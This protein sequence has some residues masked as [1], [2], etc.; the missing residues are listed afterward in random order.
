MGI[1]DDFFAE[2]TTTEITP[3]V[4][5]FNDFFE[6][7]PVAPTPQISI[8]TPQFGTPSL[9]TT[10]QTAV[11][12]IE[13]IEAPQTKSVMDDFFSDV[14]IPQ[15]TPQVS[16]MDDFFGDVFIDDYKPQR[17][18]SLRITPERSFIQKITDPIEKLYA[19]SKERSANIL[20]LSQVTGLSITQVEKHYRQV[21]EDV[22]IKEQPSGLEVVKKT[23]ELAATGLIVSGLVAAPVV[24]LVG[25]SAF[26][27][28]KGTAEYVAL[29]AAKAAYQKLTSKEVQYEVT[30]LRD[31]VPGDFLKDTADLAEFV[32]YGMVA[33]KAVA[34]IKAL[35]PKVLGQIN[36]LRYRIGKAM[37]KKFETAVVP[38]GE[39]VKT[40]PA[41]VPTTVEP[42]DIIPGTGIKK[43]VFPNERSDRPLMR[44]VER[45]EFINKGENDFLT[46]P[47]KRMGI[48]DFFYTPQ[49]RM[50]QKSGLGRPGKITRDATLDRRIEIQA[51]QKFMVDAVSELK[52]DLGRRGKTSQ[53]DL[54]I[55]LAKV[56]NYMEH[57]VPET[58]KTPA[59]RFAKAM[60]Y[61]TEQMRIRINQI[62]RESGDK[63]IGNVKD[64]ILHTV[65]DEILH[66]ILNTGEVS[67]EIA[68]VLRY[69]PDKKV[70]LKTALERKEVPESWLVKDPIKLMDAMYKIDLK[71]TYLQDSLNRAKP[72][73]QFLEDPKKLPE[74]AVGF[75]NSV[76]KYWNYYKDHTLMNK[77]STLDGILNNSVDAVVGMVL[78]RM[79]KIR[80]RLNISH[81]PY[82]QTVNFILG[83]TYAG[84][85]G[86]RA[87]PILRNL[88]QGTFDW[89]MYGTKAYSKGV[90][91]R[92]TK[93]GRDILSQSKIWKTRTPFEF[94]L[95]GTSTYKKLVRAGSVPYR[96][97]DQQN[98][99]NAL[100]TRYYYAKDT[101]K[102]DHKKA[103]TFADNDLPN[104]QWSYLRED[105]PAAFMTTSGRAVHSLG[106]WW[107]NYYTRLLPEI[108]S[109]TILGKDVSGRKVTGVERLAGLRYFALIGALY[110][111]RELTNSLF[112]TPIDYT[113]QIKPSPF[114]IAPLAQALVQI[115]NMSQGFAENSTS[116][117][118]S[119]IN[120]L[121]RTLKVI[122]PFGLTIDDTWKTIQGEKEIKESLL[123][124]QRN[125]K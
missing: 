95:E 13:T 47:R 44:L 38:I 41:G 43:P 90:A 10:P 9:S 99:A 34:G 71:Y 52:S 59:Q 68:A 112:G 12:D 14:D 55:E 5:I 62:K 101:L 16:A 65:K 21:I 91:K 40:G 29:P 124:I 79:P 36:G 6:D 119:A 50:L 73:T 96:L 39:T 64:Y 70:F 105:M 94:E 84:A 54:E 118:N 81:R 111:T 3:Q 57:G 2:D 17:E 58:P 63:E 86:A 92:V 48:I 1:F 26:L 30:Q 115:K 98:V 61:E 42:K 31:L 113:G 123:Y 77:P 67:T 24:T 53:K 72:Y 82:E 104:T 23:F 109:R 18:T 76:I 108:Y 25:L 19:P 74:G 20:R 60:R 49:D 7:T 33:G 46:A 87:K 122:I 35:G 69:I 106:S 32:I 121:G 51:K 78:N 27:A 8:P 97:S 15:D 66:E 114:G 85:L 102:M 100:L 45:E 56:W 22:G 116:K 117:I 75:D 28:V 80:G 107:M 110:G 93:E 11:E 103:L 83:T 4:G 88:T 37:G 120:Q 89:V 125:R